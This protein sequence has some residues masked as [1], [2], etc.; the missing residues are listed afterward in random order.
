M[1]DYIIENVD[2]FL[3]RNEQSQVVRHMPWLSGSG[4]LGKRY[5]AHVRESYIVYRLPNFAVPR[6]VSPDPSG[7]E[8]DDGEGCEAEGAQPPSLKRRR[9]RRL[10]VYEEWDME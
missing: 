2:G 9:K 1:S 6:P 8:R 4:A 3:D 7:Q 10:V 5:V